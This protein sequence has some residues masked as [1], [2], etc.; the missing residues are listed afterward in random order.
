MPVSMLE[1]F[2]WFRILKISALNCILSLSVMG[3]FFIPEISPWKN[4]GPRIEF[5][6]MFA[7]WSLGCPKLR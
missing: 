4:A 7:K 6:P 1:K 5:R 3:K 2:G